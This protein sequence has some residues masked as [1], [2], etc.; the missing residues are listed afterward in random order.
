MITWRTVILSVYALL[1]SGKPEPTH[2][3][4]IAEQYS[5]CFDS[6]FTEHEKQILR[7]GYSVW[8][9]DKIRFF[10]SNTCDTYVVKATEEDA[11]YYGPRY[12]GISQTWRNRI[13]LFPERTN[14]DD[15]M[16]RW[17]M[18]H[19]VGHWIGLQHVNP[20]DAPAVMNSEVRKEVTDDFKLYP[21]DLE[22]L[23]N[24]WSCK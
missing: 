4:H 8:N 3:Y 21:K 23:C 18:G 7:Q 17:I 13:V 12:I 1:C 22:Q 11:I 5:L 19:E 6:A 10:E 9:T 15:S 2:T 14:H 24:L 16:L 20:F